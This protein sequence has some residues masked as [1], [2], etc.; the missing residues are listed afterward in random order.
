MAIK[1]QKGNKEN[2]ANGSCMRVKKDTKAG[3]DGTRTTAVASQPPV[4]TE[5]YVTRNMG[6]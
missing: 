2:G 3:K 6:A 4:E 5:T 1:R